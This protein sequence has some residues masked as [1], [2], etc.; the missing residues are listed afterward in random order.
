[1]KVLSNAEAKKYISG[2]AVHW[3]EKDAPFDLLSQSYD[4]YQGNGF[5]LETEACQGINL[6][7]KLVQ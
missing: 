3:Y 6:R 5:V 7:F 4:L 2:S 1:M